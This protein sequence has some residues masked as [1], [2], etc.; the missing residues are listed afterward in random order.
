MADY[1]ADM[2]GMVS[3]RRGGV[4]MMTVLILLGIAGIVGFVFLAQ[5]PSPIHVIPASS[6]DKD[7]VEWRT[8]LEA[9]MAESQRVGRPVLIDFTASWCPPCTLMKATTWADKAVIAKANSLFI[10]VMIDVDE[11]PAIAKRFDVEAYPTV[12]VLY[13]GKVRYSEEAYMGPE[14]VLEAVDELIAK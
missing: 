12:M 9:A 1:D 5:R 6:F 2:Q 8:D 13:N 10:P 14:Q 7:A 3:L 4:D 11:Q